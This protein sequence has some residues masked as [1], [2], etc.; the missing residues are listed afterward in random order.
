MS[1]VEVKE[2]VKVK[3]GERTVS[4]SEILVDLLARGFENKLQEL[5]EE[6]LRGECS[7]EYFAE[8]LGLN[9]WEATNILERRGLKTTKL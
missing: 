9:V 8:Q 2:W 1:E 7:L 6:F 5:H 4:G 3:F